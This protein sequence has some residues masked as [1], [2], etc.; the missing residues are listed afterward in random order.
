MTA[1]SYPTT[2]LFCSLSRLKVK[3]TL[4]F[5]VLPCVAQISP[6]THPHR[7]VYYTI[8]VSSCRNR[9]QP[10]QCL[11]N[12]SLSLSHQSGRAPWGVRVKGFERPS[13]WPQS[14]GGDD[15]SFPI[16]LKKIIL[17]RVYRYFTLS[18]KTRI[19]SLSKYIKYKALTISLGTNKCKTY[20]NCSTIQASVWLRLTEYRAQK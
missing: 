6:V 5:W 14:G 20:S 11:C 16:A 10:A 17:M 1:V 12:S 4:G 9:S 19:I 18:F 15:D 2:I 8:I 3:N 13:C 7:P